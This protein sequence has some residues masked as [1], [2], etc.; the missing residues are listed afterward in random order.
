MAFRRSLPPLLALAAATL[1]AP[2]AAQAHGSMASPVSRV[3]HCA[4]GNIE[5][6]S[7]PGCAQAVQRYG[8]GAFYN[9]NGV[10][11]ANANGNHRAVVPD[12]QL[13]SGGNAMFRALDD[14]TIPWTATPIAPGANGRFEFVFRATAPHATRNW[15]FYVTPANWTPGTP[16][17]WDMMEEFCRLGSVPLS[18]GNVYRMSC[19]LPQRSGRHVIY[20]TWQRSDSTEAFYTCSDV[21][22]TGGTN[23]GWTDRGPLMAQNA[24]PVDSVVTLRLFNSAGNDVES[25]AHTVTASQTAPAD[26]AYALAQRVNQQSSRARIG[27]IDAAG[28][29]T[30]QRSATANRVYTQASQNL[31]YQVDIRTPEPN[32]DPPVARIQPS[33]TE[34][35]GAG[36]VTLSAAGST[37]PNGRPLTYQWQVTSGQGQLSSSSGVQTTLQLAAPAQ[38]QV[39][40]VRLTVNNGRDT[41]QTSV[42][43]NHRTAGGG[44]GDHDYVYPDGIGNYRAGETVVKGTDGNLYLCRPFPFGGWCNVNSPAYAP[45]TGWAWQ[46]AWERL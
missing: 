40:V 2:D 19:T 42:S 32:G 16:L 25:I 12:R 43:I 18:A 10:N 6:P 31:S 36:S 22:F 27:V 34:V 8:T 24:L 9:W 14:E 7:D 37:D 13:C 28:Q 46:D 45:G 3:Y 39:V 30:P 1:L 20:N 35:I 21:Q 38:N 44:G 33:A 4:Q 26:W 23:P 17:R 11:Q 5:R 41:H 15:V 29:V